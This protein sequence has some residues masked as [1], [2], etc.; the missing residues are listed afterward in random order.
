[1]LFSYAVTRSFFRRLERIPRSV[2]YWLITTCSLITLFAPLLLW[3]VMS[4]VG[5]KILLAVWGLAILIIYI[6]I[7][8]SPDEYF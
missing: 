1:M 5:Y 8:T 3:V 4:L 6:L 2:R 7:L